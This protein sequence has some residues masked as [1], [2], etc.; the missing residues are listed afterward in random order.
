MTEMIVVVL[1]IVDVG[2]DDG[3]PPLRAFGP[4]PLGLDGL[5]EAPAVGDTGQGVESRQMR[6]IQLQGNR[7]NRC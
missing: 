3:E 6:Q 4:L 1:E 2:N 5:V 7:I